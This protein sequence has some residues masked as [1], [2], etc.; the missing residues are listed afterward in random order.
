[1]GKRLRKPKR[2]TLDVAVWARQTDG[3][4]CG[5]SA[6][7]NQQ[8]NMCCLGQFCRQ[9]GA[10]RGDILD[11]S[12]PDNMQKEFPLMSYKHKFIGLYGHTSKRIKNTQF[13]NLAVEINDDDK[14]DDFAK[15]AKLRKLCKRHGVT[16]V[17]KNIKKAIKHDK[18]T[19]S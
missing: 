16:L 1:M 7:L 19:N 8:N 18:C 15:I 9:M 13:S 12:L 5:D 17:V 6:L 3:A 14:T 10:K 11:T 2:L 4:I